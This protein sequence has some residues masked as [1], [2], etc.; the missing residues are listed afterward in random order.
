MDNNDPP[1]KSS[2][3][4]KNAFL[5]ELQ[6]IK[7]ILDDH[8]NE[9]QIDVPLLND[10]VRDLGTDGTLSEPNLDELDTSPDSNEHAL[11]ATADDGG[12]M[13]Q[14]RDVTAEPFAFPDD[15]A[16]DYLS[17]EQV[18][19]SGDEFKELGA[20]QPEEYQ[21]EQQEF[22]PSVESGIHLNDINNTEDDNFNLELLIQEVVDEVIPTVENELRKRLSLCSPEMIKRLAEKFN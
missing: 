13:L 3:T 11:H 12:P 2:S 5:D 10:I 20:T 9:I 6:S 22:F 18:P 17:S 7:G 8:Q 19:A 14:V 16:E 21:E 1:P 15:Y 4:N